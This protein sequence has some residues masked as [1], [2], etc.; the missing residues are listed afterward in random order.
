MICVHTA[1][2]CT[3]HLWPHGAVQAWGCSWWY[4]TFHLFTTI[5]VH[6]SSG[7]I[8]PKLWTLTPQ[9]ETT[10]FASTIWSVQLCRQYMNGRSELSVSKS[11]GEICIMKVSVKSLQMAASSG[12][13][14]NLVLENC[15]ETVGQRLGC[16]GLC[17]GGSNPATHRGEG[18]CSFL[19]THSFHG[20]W[21]L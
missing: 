12:E 9:T 11:E 18:R 3:S 10:W 15:R 17:S 2:L 19:C 6:V 7:N 16:C 5:Y 4:M 21:S 8:K 13:N 1:W 20:S 14:S